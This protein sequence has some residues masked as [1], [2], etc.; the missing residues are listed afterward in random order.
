MFSV[1]YHVDG[2]KFAPNG[3]ITAAD[4]DWTKLFVDLVNEVRARHLRGRADPPVDEGRRGRSSRRSARPCPRTCRTRSRT[5]QAEDPQRRVQHLRR[6]NQGPGGCREA[7]R[8]AKSRTPIALEST[9]YL[10]EGVTGQDPELAYVRIIS[11]GGG[12]T[13]GR[14]PNPSRERN[15]GGGEHPRST[16][17]PRGRGTA[18]S[19]PRRAAVLVLHDGLE[20]LP[21]GP[22]WRAARAVAAGVQ[23]ARGW[24]LIALPPAHGPEARPHRPRYLRSGRP[25][26]THRWVHR[27]RP[28]LQSCAAAQLTDLVFAG[29]PFELGADTTMREANDLGYECLALSTLLHRRRARHPRRRPCQHPDVRRHLRRCRHDRPIPC[30]ARLLRRHAAQRQSRSPWRPHEPQVAADPYAWPFNGELRPLADGAR[31]ASI[32]RSTSAARAAMST[33]WATTSTSRAQASTQPATVLNLV[34]GHPG[35]ARR[36]HARRPQAGP[37]RLPAEQALAVEADG[38]RHR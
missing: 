38:C 36:P 15:P 21:G 32:G 5:A 13:P 3:W 22:M 19:S 30:P 4:W 23:R 17:L 14:R 2:S 29:F 24:R 34:R 26:A 27:H 31:A 12:Q 37:F 11:R 25:A 35:D 18:I 10:V 1:G 9:N 20:H 33:P 28:R 6:P 8:P 16:A 7:S